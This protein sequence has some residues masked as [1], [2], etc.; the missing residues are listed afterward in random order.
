MPTTRDVADAELATTWYTAC[1]GCSL[2]QHLI[3]VPFAF[4]AGGGTV[5]VDLEEFASSDVTRP[6]VTAWP[7]CGTPSLTEVSGTRC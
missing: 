4:G 6:R 7:G 2:I 1:Y 3:Q 5:E